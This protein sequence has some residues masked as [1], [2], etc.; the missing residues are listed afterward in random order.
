MILRFLNSMT[1]VNARYT[2]NTI[3][4]KNNVE[5][6][7]YINKE[8]KVNACIYFL[9]G[10]RW[11]TGKK[12][13]F[14]FVA[15]KFLKAGYHV[16]I[17]DYRKHPK[18]RFPDFVEDAAHGLIAVKNHFENSLKDATSIYVMG[19]SSGAHLGAMLCTDS[20]FLDKAGGSMDAINGFIGISGPY[21]FIDY[22]DGSD[23]LPIMFGPP[24]R[25]SDSQPVFLAE[26]ADAL[27]PMLLIHGERDKSVLP[28][29][30][31]RLAEAV[32]QKSKVKT[33]FLSNLNHIGTIAVFGLPFWP[34][35]TEE[36]MTAI[37]DFIQKTSSSQNFQ[38]AI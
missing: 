9:Y 2:L 12:K 32:E 30:T 25:Y 5:V 28:F 24:E 14:C 34:K 7:L 6:N 29:N 10:G 8:S 13:D 11:T 3:Q 23:D 37:N 19:H 16:A 21:K 38:E 26:K 20:R 18:V 27:P 15:H 35:Q 33:L 36:I 1:K 22:I 31:V 4:H 17:A